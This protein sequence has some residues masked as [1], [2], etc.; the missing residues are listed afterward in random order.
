MIRFDRVSFRY[1]Q[2]KETSFAIRE[3][4]FSL[5]PTRIIGF[6]GGNGSGKSTF[7]RL[8]AGINL[9]Q[10][11]TVEVCGIKTCSEDA[12][13]HRKVG[14]IFQNP[15]NQI[16]GTTVEEDIA[17]GLENLA[18]PTEEMDDI[19]LAI[20]SEFK[21]VDLLKK[22]VHQLSGGQKQLVC[23]AAV[24]V[25]QPDWLIFDEP[26]SHLDPWARREF[27]KTLRQVLKKR[28]VGIIVIS[29]ISEDFDNFDEVKVF[30]QGQIAFS[31]NI[32]QFKNSNELPDLIKVPEK[33]QFARLM[34]QHK[35]V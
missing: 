4:S 21:I 14:I 7:A 16:V 13:I 32:E 12:Q 19:I 10:E 9:P 33:W 27:W 11:G 35:N 6:V 2:R 25:M 18:V 1:D 20:A 8:I 30:S 23:I 26:T 17:F 29:Q 22:P 15:E 28:D 34:E 31:G 3:V 24:M 5:L